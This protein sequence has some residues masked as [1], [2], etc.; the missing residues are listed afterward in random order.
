LDRGCEAVCGTL[1]TVCNASNSSALMRLEPNS[2]PTHPTLVAPY[3]F[4]SPGSVPRDF[5]QQRVPLALPEIESD[6]VERRYTK[7]GEVSVGVCSLCR[8][9][10]CAAHRPASGR[11]CAACH[12]KFDKDGA[13]TPNPALQTAHR[14][15][16]GAAAGLL[17]L[18]GLGLSSLLSPTELLVALAYALCRYAAL[19]SDNNGV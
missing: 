17:L 16:R 4:P 5:C 10:V 8:R 1:A 7:C 3:R 15:G 11:R 13:S 14:A 2:E 9:L 6:G 12:G 18:L 19:R